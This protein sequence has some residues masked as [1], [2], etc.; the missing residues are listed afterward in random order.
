MKHILFLLG[1]RNPESK[2][3]AF[4][5]QVA[6]ELDSDE[7]TTEILTPQD[8]KLYPVMDATVFLT[9]VDEADNLEGD[10]GVILKEKILN[11]DLVVFGTPV[12]AHAVSSD[13]KL[14]IERISG[15]LHIFGLLGKP[16]I[17]VVAASN[18]GFTG[19]QEYL[20]YVMD[21]LGMEVV[22]GVFLLDGEIN[23]KDE[24]SRV[25]K[26]IVETLQPDHRP[27]VGRIAEQQFIHY[28]RTYKPLSRELAEPKYWESK[29]WFDC[30]SL[31][32]YL[33]SCVDA[34]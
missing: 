29:G 16:G 18:N 31:Q 33:D 14:L 20:E 2:Q 17:S 15:W 12:Y 10:H 26:A 13:I 34:R 7:Y 8:W 6:S 22:E 32:A 19:V 24:V 11:A 9:G 1:S 28:Q 4:A 23:Y 21:S 3:L 30:P 5:K 25:C 27:T